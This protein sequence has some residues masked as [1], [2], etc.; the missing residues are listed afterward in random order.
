MRFSNTL[1]LYLAKHFFLNFLMILMIILSVVYLFDSIEILRRAGKFENVTLPLVFKISLLKLPEVGQQIVPFAV[2]FGAMFSFWQLMRRYEIIVLKASGF[3][4]W[5]LLMPILLVGTLIGISQATVINPISAALLVKYDEM[6]RRY[7]SKSSGVVSLFKNGMWIRQ[8]LNDNTNT[9]N[10]NNGYVILSGGKVDVNTWELQR[11]T[12]Y[13]FD[14]HNALQKRIDA[15]NASLKDNLWIFKNVSI[16]A[17]NE[18]P[19]FNDEFRFQNALMLRDIEESV[20]SV[21]SVSFWKLPYLIQN[22][23]EAGF[24]PTRLE[25]K[26][27]N[28]LATPIMMISM[29][30]LGAIVSLRPPRSNATT[31]V[32]LGGI[33]IGFIIFFVQ[34]FLNAFGMSNQLPVILAAWSPSVISLMI[35]IS[36]LINIEDG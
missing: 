12:A 4:I 3:S 8:P 5:Q 1:N 14:K 29:I 26:L 36:I 32:I 9:P 7:L 30:I 17:P 23:R 16:N 10:M 21:G 18:D 25:L 15:Q 11:V 34:N 27:H 33:F 31:A 28:L 22:L 35:G 6:E 13:F 24:D 20:T 2:L 19:V